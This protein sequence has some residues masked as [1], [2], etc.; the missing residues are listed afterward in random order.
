MNSIHLPVEI[1]FGVGSSERV[2]T[3]FNAFKCS[4]I[5]IVTDSGIKNAGILNNICGVLDKFNISY[6]IFSEVIPDPNI[7]SIN[8]AK[9][10]YDEE[11]CDGILAIGGGSSIDTAKAMGAIITNH[12][13]L[14]E[15]SGVGK[16]KNPLPPLIAIPTTCGT[17]SEVTNV[18]VVTN[19]DHFKTPFLS[20]HLIPK[21]AILDPNLL[22]T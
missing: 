16:I 17:G 10:I 2:G 20:K 5:I 19:N 18:T 3:H 13:S 14:M 11:E 22:N 21:V 1:E 15:L 9:K 6:I 8:K 4:R 12:K 7:D